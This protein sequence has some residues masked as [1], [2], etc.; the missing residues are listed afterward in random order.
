M[1]VVLQQ[2]RVQSKDSA[3]VTHTVTR[4][5][6]E[7][8]VARLRFE[9]FVLGRAVIMTSLF[10]R[11]FAPSRGYSSKRI[12]AP[13]GCAGRSPKTSEALCRSVQSLN[14]PNRTTEVKLSVPA[15]DLSDFYAAIV[16]PQA[17][18]VAKNK[19][20]QNSG[21]NW[22]RTIMR[23]LK[24]IVQ[25]A[26][27][28]GLHSPEVQKIK[29]PSLSNPVVGFGNAH[30]GYTET[31]HCTKNGHTQCHLVIIV[32]FRTHILTDQDI[33]RRTCLIPGDL[34]ERVWGV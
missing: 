26:C 27:S 18:C 23:S 28:S 1:D 22:S 32:E 14:G 30:S 29:V 13:N 8:P 34:V 21:N 33:L 6:G 25:W 2:Y 11:G 24:T 20:F 10:P 4:V 19:Y 5:A 3:K 12:F 7:T 9:G 31:C 16:L 15:E 17:S